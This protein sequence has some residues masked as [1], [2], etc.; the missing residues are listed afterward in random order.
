MGATKGLV[1]IQKSL[2]LP[3]NTQESAPTPIADVIS[4]EKQKEKVTPNQTEKSTL[5]KNLKSVEKAGKIVKLAKKEKMKIRKDLLVKKLTK[6]AAEKKEAIEKKKREKVV[7]VKDT[8]PLLQNL[9]E[10]EKEIVKEDIDKLLKQKSTT[11]ISKNTKKIKK[12]K[13]QFMKDIE[14]LKAASQDP[15]YVANPLK[16]VTTHIQNSIGVTV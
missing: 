10:I 8:M 7:I 11:K 15:N 6:H 4:F 16:T 3:T 5:K 9:E 14:F 13:E 2:K 1:D 12:Q